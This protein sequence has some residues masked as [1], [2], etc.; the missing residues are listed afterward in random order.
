M[1]GGSSIVCSP[2]GVYFFFL[3]WNGLI[4]VFLLLGRRVKHEELVFRILDHPVQHKALLKKCT[5]HFTHCTLDAP[6]L[7][8]QITLPWIFSS[9]IFTCR[10]HK[11]TTLIWTLHHS[12]KSPWGYQGKP[13]YLFLYLKPPLGIP[14]SLWLE[15]ISWGPPIAPSS[16][17]LVRQ[18]KSFRNIHIFHSL[19]SNLF[20]IITRFSLHLVYFPE[21]TRHP[22][23]MWKHS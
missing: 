18:I 12:L 4:S 7:L 5:I 14:P 2:S 13:K 15:G 9:C 17:M 6:I 8:D 21:A 1:Q 20:K 3:F 16:C 22:F 11:N 10:S 23:V 19:H